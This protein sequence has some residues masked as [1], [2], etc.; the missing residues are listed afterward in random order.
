MFELLGGQKGGLKYFY[1][2][3]TNMLDGQGPTGY[4]SAFMNSMPYLYAVKRSPVLLIISLV[5]VCVFLTPQHARAQGATGG[6]YAAGAIVQPAQGKATSVDQAAFGVGADASLGTNSTAIGGN[7][8]AS[9]VNSTT[10]GNFSFAKGLNATTVGFSAGTN[11]ATPGVTSV[12]TFVN[13]ITAGNYSTAMGAGAAFA[14]A[15]NSTGNF[16]VA[17]G[18]GD[19][20]GGIGAFASG[21]SSIAMGLSSRATGLSSLSIGGTGAATRASL[22]TGGFDTAVGNGNQSSGVGATAVGDNNTVSG[23]FSTAIGAFNN[24]AGGVSGAN[25]TAVGSSN[26]ASGANSVAIGANNTASGANA[27]AI[28]SG[29]SATFANSAAIGVGATATRPNQMVFGTGTSTY[30]TPGITSAASAAAQTGPT[31]FVTSDAAGDLATSAF[32]PSSF[33]TLNNRINSVN[34]RVTNVR[35]EER[36][37]VALAMATG[38]V[39]YDDQPGKISVGGGVGVFED[40]GGAALGVGFTSPNG[41]VRGNIAGGGSFHGEFGGAAGLSITLN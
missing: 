13:G 20:V 11:A 21:A 30:T 5:A 24:F 14:N 7:A 17:I 10:V 31:N 32:G 2:S 37:G 25:S 40:Q 36:G 9:G 1:G 22:A 3:L 38:Q 35:N 29:S 19:G 4:F 27:I 18:G 6:T 16:S 26:T 33:I 23:N 39:R 8:I 28:G 41:R 15:A 12:G 34:A